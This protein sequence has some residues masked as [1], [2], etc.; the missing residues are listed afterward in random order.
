MEGAD[1]EA[2]FA[3]R[4]MRRNPTAERTMTSAVSDTPGVDFHPAIKERPALMACE[5]AKA[6]RDRLA[7]QNGRP[8]TKGDL[9]LAHFGY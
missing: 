6:S 9:Y 3:A 2:M 4:I 8:L 7:G 1:G 5:M